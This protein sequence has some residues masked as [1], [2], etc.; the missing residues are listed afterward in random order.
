[1]VYVVQA[2]ATVN[3]I[4]TLADPVDPSLAR[5]A[6]IRELRSSVVVAGEHVLI[7]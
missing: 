6:L 4:A 3:T 2:G 7:P 5:R 1:M